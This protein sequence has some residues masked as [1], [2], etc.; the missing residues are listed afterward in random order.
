MF[1]F[2]VFSGSIL[3]YNASITFQTMGAENIRL[4]IYISGNGN[5]FKQS[6]SSDMIFKILN[7]LFHFSFIPSPTIQSG[8]NAIVI[9]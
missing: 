4:Q 7:E 2:N 8:L 1:L 3:T 9:T 5:D 6:S